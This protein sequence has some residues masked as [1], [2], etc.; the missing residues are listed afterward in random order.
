MFSANAQNEFTT[1]TKN[2]GLTSTN[3]LSTKVDYRGI[4]W[5]ATNSGINA[6]VDDGWIPIKSIADKNGKE[7]KIG[8]VSNIFESLNG[9]L[10]VVSEKGLFVYNGKH[11]THFYD[12]DNEGFVVTDIF[13][14]RRG[15]IWILLEKKRSLKDIGDLGFALTEGKI[16]TY[17]GYQ[18]YKHEGEIGGSAAVTIGD[19]MEYFTSHTQDEQGNI[20]ITN[21]DGL[22]SFNGKK[23][24]KFDEEEKQLPAD[25]CNKV[26]ETNNNEIWVATRHGIAKQKDGSWVK[27]EDN[28]GLKGKNISDLFEDN[29]N[30]LWATTKKDNRFSSLCLYENNIWKPYNKDDIKIV[31]S[32]DQLID[33]DDQLIAFS[34]SGVSLFDGKKWINLI[35]KNKIKDDKY[36]GVTVTRDKS[37]WFAGQKGLYRLNST[38]L[39]LVYSPNKSWKVTTIFE[40]NT[41]EIWVGT[42]KKGVCVIGSTS[43]K[44]YTVN[45]GFNDNYIKD[46]FEDKQ[47]N[48]WV[49]TKGGISKYNK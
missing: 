12:G 14:D 33:F 45:N 31:G 43:N 7:V 16:Q 22:Y 15:W 39:Q 37:V 21:L 38:G 24:A 18:W 28:K 8:R 4:V 20:W 13:E 36:T 6:Y 40:T 27:Y 2:D 5:A 11:W 3:I 25:I 19:P 29:Q 9:E 46:I 42:E 44:H 23:W 35:K 34:K 49:V 48:I 41:G 1:H 26:L 47:N 17:N 30:R 10:W 32:I